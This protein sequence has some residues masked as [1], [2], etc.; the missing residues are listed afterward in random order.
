LNRKA[1]HSAKKKG[2]R[3]KPI[4]WIA[5]VTLLAGLAVIAGIY[6]EQNTRISGV[7]FK[8]NFFTTDEELF[9]RIESPIGT[10]ADSV[11]YSEM[12][13]S[14][15]SL[16]YVKDLS[17]S[18]SIRGRL[19]F[20]VHEYEP[21]ALLVDGSNRIYVTDGG[22]KL[23]LIPEKIKDVPLV[24]GFPVQPQSDTLNSN[25]WKQIEEF[26]TEARQRN[27]S[28][29]TISEVAWNEREGV[30]ALTHE[31]GVKLVF[32]HEMFNER[33]NHWEVFYTEVVSRKGIRSFSS[34]DLR[35]RNQIV[36]HES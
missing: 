12:F 30:V 19:S 5:G 27:I 36:T 29:V 3:L 31:N 35:F 11:D 13:I 15:K 1:S 14:L 25:S 10:L 17:L 8:G 34:I 28:W 33:L 21:L 6:F 4:S 20:N 9:N 24:Y 26:L 22:L 23:P 18:M 16:P 32:G 2:S 7:E